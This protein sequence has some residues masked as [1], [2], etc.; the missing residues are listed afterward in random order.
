MAKKVEKKTSVELLRQQGDE[1]VSAHLTLE[2]RVA[3]LE[4]DMRRMLAGFE[5]Q[6]GEGS[7]TSALREIVLKKQGR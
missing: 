5:K 7:F 3:E 2:E 6:F 4:G 1:L